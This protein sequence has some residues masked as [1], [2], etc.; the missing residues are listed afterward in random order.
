LVFTPETPNRTPNLSH[1]GAARA[2]VLVAV[3]ILALGDQGQVLA[4]LVERA[5]AVQVDRAGDAPFQGVGH[6]ALGHV[7]AGEQFR[8][9]EVQVDFAVGAAAVGAAVRG[10]RD[11]G[12]VE[13]HLGEAGTQ[14][15]DRDLHAFAVD[16]AVD[17]DARNA[18]QG[19][20]QVG[21]RQLADVLGEDAVAERHGVALGE[22][23]LLQAAAD[24]GDDDFLDRRVRGVGGRG[25]GR[26]GRR[27]RRGLGVGR[28][29]H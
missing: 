22:G 5:G 16:V 1:Q 7:Q 28:G 19:L 18:V 27:G 11:L 14:A 8:R 9:E 15:A 6:R 2:R 3:G 24:A 29:G 20:G 4:F 12:V 17:L 21:G 10:H 25:L 26:R 23:R 13:Q